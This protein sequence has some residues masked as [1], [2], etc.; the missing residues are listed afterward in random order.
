MRFN[1]LIL[2]LL[3]TILLFESE[4]VFSQE[5]RSEFSILTMGNSWV[6]NNPS[7]TRNVITREGIKNWESKDARIRT[8]FKVGNKGDLT[9]GL[10]AKNS[11]GKSTLKVSV[12]G[13]SKNIELSNSEFE[14]IQVGTFEIEKEGYHFVELQ[15]VSKEG[16]TF[17]EVSEIILS[18]EASKGDLYFV[19][20]DFYWGRRGPS[21]HLTYQVPEE[22]GDIKYFYNEMTIPKDN[23]VVG[24]YFM[25]NGFAEGY[26]G[27]QVNS[28]TERRILFSVWS[29]FKTDDPKS[30]P[31]DQRI[32]LLKKGDDVISNDFGNEG[33]GGQSR[34]VFH[35]KSDTTY[36]FLLKAEPSIN[37]ST[38]YTAYFYAP[39]TEKWELIASFRRPK[40]STYVKRPHSFL[41]NFITS[42]GDETR[43]VRYNNQWLMNTSGKWY[44]VDKVKFTA[45]A[46][47][48]KDSRLDYAGGVEGNSF[49]L[50][51]CGFFSETTPMNSFFSKSVENVSPP[52]ID[53]EKLP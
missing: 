1:K 49:Y 36:K 7:E 16:T 40:T 44:P 45:D 13:V 30:I 12:N 41:E 11:T 20:E 3:S 27:I 6:Y 21:V 26:F 39:E 9:I 34:K 5:K 53:F 25:A 42:M 31:E 38:D 35:W 51:N 33:S 17:G 37:N 28:E 50:Q 15:G 48:R 2:L 46:T 32:K 18:G 8:Y 4:S 23:D 22:A 24:S 29:P 43:K 52:E 14:T 47:A 19:K 10:K